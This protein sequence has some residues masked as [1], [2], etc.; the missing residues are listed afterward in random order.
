M[1]R[2][3]DTGMK[4][5]SNSVS[6]E[7]F[8]YF[9]CCYFRN[10]RCVTSNFFCVYVSWT[11]SGWPGGLRLHLASSSWY[12]P[13]PSNQLVAEPWVPP[14]LAAHPMVQGPGPAPGLLQAEISGL[15]PSEASGVAETHRAAAHWCS[16]TVVS[17]PWG[18]A[19]S[20]QGLQWWARGAGSTWPPWQQRLGVRGSWGALSLL[21]TTPPPCQKS[22]IWLCNK[23]TYEV[24]RADDKNHILHGATDV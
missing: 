1:L 3:S 12:F 2:L 15:L 14:V 7:L 23:Q 24:N 19:S 6:T 21:L 8:L 13:V 20:P 4:S 22:S 16:P 10:F 18:V 9:S 5:H 17:G 11:C